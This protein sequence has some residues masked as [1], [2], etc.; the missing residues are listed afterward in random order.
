MSG[1]SE[2]KRLVL[3][4]EVDERKALVVGA[5]AAVRVEGGRGGVARY[6]AEGHDRWRGGRWGR[7]SW[8]GG[9]WGRHRWR[10]GQW[11]RHR[12]RGGQWGRDSYRSAA[13]AR[14]DGA[15]TYR[16]RRRHQRGA[17]SDGRAVQVAP[18]KPTLIAPGTKRL[19]LTCDERLSDFAFNFN[20][21][22]YTM[23][24]SEPRTWTS[25]IV[26]GG[27]RGEAVQVDPMK[28]KLKAFFTKRLKLNCDAPLSSFAFKFN[29]RRYVGGTTHAAV[30]SRCSPLCSGSAPHVF[31]T[32]STPSPRCAPPPKR[33][34]CTRLG[35]TLVHFSA[36]LEP[37][38]SPENALHTR[39]T[40]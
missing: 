20:L 23:A 28:P 33:V 8:R 24:R 32:W 26:K 36:Q 27:R 35:L 21:R 39:N 34:T 2:Q 9:Q 25:L 38:M 12:W 3:S 11:G 6:D 1:S 18:I 15:G 16:C 5:D 29:L 22:C 30:C 14:R 37:C 19:K 17:D 31:P 10:G 4:S 7:D 40:S 13:A